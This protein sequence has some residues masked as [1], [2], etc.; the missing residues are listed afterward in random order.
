VRDVSSCEGP[1]RT[2]KGH[3]SW[4][5]FLEASEPCGR[6]YRLGLGWLLHPKLASLGALLSATGTSVAG[7]PFFMTGIHQE[8][9]G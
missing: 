9:L 3:N 4:F 6:T 1:S 7:C 2:R 5:L 8:K